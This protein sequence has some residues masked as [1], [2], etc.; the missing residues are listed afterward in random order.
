[1]GLTKRRDSYYVEF[2]VLDDGKTLRLAS[3]IA[4]ARLKR[5]KVGSLNKTTAK[6]QEALIKTDLMKGLVVSEGAQPILFRQWGMEYLELEEVK[7]LA[8]YQ[9]RREIMLCQLIPFFGRKLLQEIR[10]GD[11]ETYRSQRKRKDGKAAKVQTINNDHIILKHCLNVAKRKGLI[12]GNPAS[13]V[14]IPNAQNER[15]RVLSGGEWAALFQSAERHIQPV[16]LMAYHIGQRAGELLKLTWDRVD[17]TRGMITLRAI[18][19]KTKMPRQIPMT[20]R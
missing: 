10:P 4:G 12:F 7:R 11:I 17:L 1:M 5:W 14:P 6:Q 20:L 13:L 9:D 15:D 19:T 18:D 8:S 16:L 3:G 2:R